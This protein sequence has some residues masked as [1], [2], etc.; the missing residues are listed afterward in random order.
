MSLLYPLKRLTVLWRS[1][2]AFF[3]IKFYIK[4]SSFWGR[5]FPTQERLLSMSSELKRVTIRAHKL[6][7]LHDELW[8]VLA[9]LAFDDDNELLKRVLRK[10]LNWRHQYVVANTAAMDNAEE[11]RLLE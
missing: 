7:E 10:H 2:C 9:D 11:E 3:R 8:D 6:E 4:I 5:L 1:R